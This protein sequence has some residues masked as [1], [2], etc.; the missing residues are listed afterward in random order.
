MNH[1]QVQ[2]CPA[3]SEGFTEGGRPSLYTPSRRTGGGRISNRQPQISPWR[4]N[5]REGACKKNLR[6]PSLDRPSHG[7]SLADEVGVAACRLWS[8]WRAWR[9]KAASHWGRGATAARGRALTR[10]SPE[11]QHHQAAVGH[12]PLA[13]DRC[14]KYLDGADD[15]TGRYLRRVSTPPQPGRGK[16]HMRRRMGRRLGPA[17]AAPMRL[18]PGSR[19][20]TL[21]GAMG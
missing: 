9:Y 10:P 1:V 16:A 5:T 13:P 12:V 11:L 21:A 8:V 2:L 18:A 6:G 7:G 14:A 20:K 3:D 17:Q 4:S 15:R 19:I